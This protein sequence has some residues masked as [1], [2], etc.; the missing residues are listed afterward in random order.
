MNKP[1]LSNVWYRVAALK[2][3]LRTHARLHRHRYRGELWYLLQDP[4]SARVHRFT[5]A[6]RLVIAAMDGQRSVADLWRLA[7]KHLGEDAPT[8]DEMIELLGQLH[9]A[10]LLQSDAT[11]DVA[12]VF[13]RGEKQERAQ[14][15]RSYANPMA[16]R[17]PLLDPE[18]FLNRFPRLLS[19]LWGRWGALLWLM[20]VVPAIV[21]VPPHWPELTHNFSDRILAV[22]NLMALW[23]VFPIIKAL[24]E[25][26]HASATK[27][28]G[29]E[30][31][32]MGIMLLVLIPVP[33]VE[34][35]AATAFR[36]KYRRAQVGAAGMLVELFL[37]AIAFYIWLASEPGIVHAFM[38]NV[39]VVAS[40]STL[41]FN[42]NP[43]L[44]YDAYY[45]LA[46]LI[47]IPN[48][49]S[50][51][52]RYLGYLIERYVLF[53]PD[54][55]PPMAT[56]AEKAWFVLYGIA[57]SIY[58]VLVTI[59]I[60]LFI[61]GKFFV[62][63]VLLALWAMFAMVVVPAAKGIQ[64]LI[65][66]PRVRQRRS[67]IVA[68]VAGLTAALVVVV[69]VIPMPFRTQAEGVIWLPERAMVRAG[70]DG[71]VGK[72]L[73]TPGSHV[74]R[75]E[76]LIKSY[77]PSLDAKI[78]IGESRVAELE[79]RY[80]AEFVTDHAKA[81]IVLDR[82]QAETAALAH[83]RERA[84]GL[85]VRAGTNGIFMVPQA[86]DM[87]GR[88]Y[89]EGALLGYVIE[90]VRP[91][92][93]VVIPQG[94]VDTVRLA[95][96]RVKVCLASDPDQTFSGHIVREVPAGGAQLP[97]K[98]LATEGGGRL[99][100]DPRDPQS[101]K[102]LDRVFQLD[103]ALTQGPRIALFGQHVYVRFSHAREPLAAQWY[104]GIR[105]LFLTRFNV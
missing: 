62:V 41:L 4:A 16:V 49:A 22:D 7:G 28:G 65:D 76:P 91:L 72:F 33:Y 6:A 82:L 38:F 104:R 46:D 68:I 9:S 26:G 37:A 47:E 8:Q 66:N 29:G 5:P 84:D 102:A 101:V 25:L 88:F 24:H 55:E 3:R 77:A 1:L 56:A 50:R 89:H 103:V 74:V 73:V 53:V 21:L 19:F 35:S 71:F 95:A 36:S 79:A 30:V 40:V 96:D 34:A 44:R 10:D 67:R 43:L 80:R 70:A 11:P 60:A 48:L 99:A 52:L 69:F 31:H 42:G 27:A 90:K 98:A 39:M 58:R 45:I 17:I 105:Q 2:P 85:T 23:L 61:A 63:G 87:P 51:A 13:A 83:V 93:R 100:A 14:Q 54:V 32:D 92:A 18:R 15:R 75:G 57:S 59:A 97:S 86:V 81:Q 64:Y 94:D 20:V 12:E 78:R